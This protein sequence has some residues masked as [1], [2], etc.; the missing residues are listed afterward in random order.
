MKKICYRAFVSYAVI[1]PMLLILSSCSNDDYLNAIP[2]NSTAL[3]AVDVQNLSDKDMSER[4][5][6]LL[7]TKDIGDC[8]LDLSSKIYLFETIE[9]NI[10]FSAK[11][12]DDGELE[13]CMGRLEKK[14]IAKMYQNTRIS[15]FLS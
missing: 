7:E 5:A 11:V 1:L 12:A 2:E 3:L 8:G 13:K 6:D 14:D 9:G 10:G 4:I 15:S